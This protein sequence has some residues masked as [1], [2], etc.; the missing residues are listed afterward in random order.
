M[1]PCQ[2]G[3]LSADGAY[4]VADRAGR[5]DRVPPKGGKGAVLL[6]SWTG[7]NVRQDMILIP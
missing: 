4:A 3:A 5:R 6:L 2:Q 1:P 7:N